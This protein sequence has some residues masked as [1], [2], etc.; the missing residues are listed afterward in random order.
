M[1]RYRTA[2][3]PQKTLIG[4]GMNTRTTPRTGLRRGLL[5]LARA[6]WIIFA[7]GNLIS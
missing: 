6:L 2:L 3:R 5:Y 7:L 4:E 1:H